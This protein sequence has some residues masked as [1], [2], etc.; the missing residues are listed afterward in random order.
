MS[1]KV[2]FPSLKIWFIV[3]ILLASAIL[4]LINV[5]NLVAAGYWQKAHNGP[6]VSKLTENEANFFWWLNLRF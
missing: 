5:E 6:E 4:I 1:K 3:L 2:K